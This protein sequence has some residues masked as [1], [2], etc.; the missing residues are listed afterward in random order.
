M[1]NA[2]FWKGASV[3]VFAIT[4]GIFQGAYPNDD[5]ANY[6]RELGV[7]AILNVSGGTAGSAAGFECLSVPFPDGHPI[8]H[9]AIE[10]CV[11]FMDR[12]IK[13]GKKVFVHCSAG[14]NRSPTIV[15]LYLIFS[16]MTAAQAFKAFEG[17]TLD[18]VPGH[19]K[20]SG[21]AQVEYVKKLSQGH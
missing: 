11:L 12:C 16:G 19:P 17:K 6:L 13:A 7:S 10:R 20:L 2:E 9:A 15:W 1:G 14:Q 21:D 5:A 8:P 18:G 3:N 4:P